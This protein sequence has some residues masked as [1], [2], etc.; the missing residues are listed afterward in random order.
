MALHGKLAGI[1]SGTQLGS[2]SLAVIDTETTGLDVA[3]AR[4]IEIKASVDHRRCDQP[5]AAP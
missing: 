5:G 2:L 4:V 3:T 1:S